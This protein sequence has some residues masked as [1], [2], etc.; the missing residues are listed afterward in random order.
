MYMSSREVLVLYLFCACSRALHCNICLV[1]TV[2]MI[3][4]TI[5]VGK[6][7]A[8]F[9]LVKPERKRIPVCDKKPLSNIKLCVV[10]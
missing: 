6:D 1:Q 5:L 8:K 2:I 7:I 10:N 3:V 9:Y 4:Y